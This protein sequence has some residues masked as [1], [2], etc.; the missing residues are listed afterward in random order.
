MP[1]VTREE[2]IR[3]LGQVERELAELRKAVQGVDVPTKDATRVF[4]EK[5][6]GWQDTRSAEETIAEIYA[7][8]DS[9][10]RGAKLFN[11]GE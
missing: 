11:Q 3:R 8:R 7:S 10:D 6:S 5:C 4:L 1:V 2:I 9:S